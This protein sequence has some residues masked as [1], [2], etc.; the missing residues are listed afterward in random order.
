MPEE[1][2]DAVQDQEPRPTEE[3]KEVITLNPA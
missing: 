2:L 3:R 1:G